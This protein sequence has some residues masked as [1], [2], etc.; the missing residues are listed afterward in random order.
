MK[1]APFAYIR[2]ETQDEALSALAEHGDDA[3]VLIE[4]RRAGGAGFGRPVIPID[5]L[6]VVIA[7]AEVAGD[8][9]GVGMLVS[10]LGRRPCRRVRSLRCLGKS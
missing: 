9:R 3:L 8:H 10:D 2:P 4:E 1:P 7:G 5:D 6:H